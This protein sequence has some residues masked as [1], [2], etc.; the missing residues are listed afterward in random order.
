MSHPSWVRGLKSAGMIVS[1]LRATGRTLH[2][3]VDWNYDRSRDCQ[4]PS[5]VAPFMGA[6]I[7]INVSLQGSI[8][9]PSSHPSWVRGLKWVVVQLL[10]MSLCGSHPSWVRGLKLWRSSSLRTK[11]IVAP[12]MGAWI[13]IRSSGTSSNRSY[14]SHPSWVR[15][16]KS[17]SRDC[18]RRKVHVAPF[19]GAW[20]EIS[21]PS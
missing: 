9:V 8:R 21:I 4:L 2:G 19:M 3:C 18:T 5:R 1:W 15:G 6:W 16:L 11:Q 14:K 20:I 12:F 7:E 17:L 10:E 13:E